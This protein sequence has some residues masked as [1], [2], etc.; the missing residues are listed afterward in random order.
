VDEQTNEVDIAAVTEVVR[1]YCDGMIKGDAA[2]LTGAFH[3][4][5]SIVGHL[6]GELYWKG[7]EDFIADSQE[8]AP[9]Q[10]PGNWRVERLAFAGDTALVTVGDE[11]D[12][13]WFS[14]D[15]SLLKVGGRWRIV[16]KT[17]YAHPAG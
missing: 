13:A 6:A 9:R 7:V 14:D 12:G 2:L 1:A 4:R 16:H 17:F 8:S 11:F 15:L 3:P 10:G 5:A